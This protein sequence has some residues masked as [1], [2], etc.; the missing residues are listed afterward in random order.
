[1]ANI[2]IS[3]KHVKD[4]ET[5]AHA[6]KKRVDKIKHH[7]EEI[8]EKFV[9]TMEVGVAAFGT[10]VLQGHGGAT[11]MGVP[12]E[13]GAAF[14]LNLLGYLGAAGKH[15]YHLNNLGDGAMAGFLVQKGQHVGAEWKAKGTLGTGTK[16]SGNKLSAQEIADIV[17][18][19]AGG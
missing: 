5:R 15:S 16:T 12:A 7:A 19:A 3:G 1:M 14:G 9:R 18:E 8:T 6:L 13:L 17:N 4:L 2:A 11:V 10:G